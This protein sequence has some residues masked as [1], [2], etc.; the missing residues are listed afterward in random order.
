MKISIKNCNNIDS[1]EIIIKEN[2]LNIK[3]AINGTGKSSISKAILYKS[4]DLKD[5]TNKILDLKPYKA[6]NDNSIIPEINGIDKYKNVQIF[7]EDYVNNYVFQGNELIKGSF[8]IFIKNDAYE[9]G[10]QEI[11]SLVEEIKTIL[12]EDK[13]IEIL[14]RDFNEMINAFGSN[15]K[16]GLDGRSSLAKAFKNGNKVENIPQELEIYT[17]YIRSSENYKWIKWQIDGQTFIDLTENCPYCV[18]DIKEKKGIIKKVAQ[19]YDAKIIE[20]MNKI[21]SVFERLDAYFSNKTKNIISDFVKN[22]DGYTSEQVDFFKELKDQI[23]RLRAKFEN[24]QNLGFY[25]LKDVDKVVDGLKEYFIDLTLYSHMESEK[26]KEKVNIVNNAL[27]N[28]QQKAGLL[29]GCIKRQQQLI[30]EIVCENKADINSFL[31]NA[32][33]NYSVDLLEETDGSRRLKLIY[34]ETEKIV[35]DVKNHLSFGEKNAIA[36]ILFMY[37]A[38]KKN[39]DLIILDD[40]ISSF[41]KNKK[42]AIIDMLFKKEKFLKGKTVLMLTHDID[43]IV[44]MMLVHSDRFE[45]P[46]ASFLENNNGLLIEKEIGRDDIKTF[47]KICKENIKE[48]HNN[49]NKLVY[50]R[51]LCELTDKNSIDYQLI[52]NLFHK[53]ETPCIYT[54]G[55]TKEMSPEEISK[56]EQRIKTIIADFSYQDYIAL[57][58]NDKDMI[59]SYFNAINNYEKLHFYRIIFDDKTSLIESDA[60]RKFI[61]ESFHIE[62]NYIYQLN[63]CK[64]QVVPQYI[65]SECDKHIKKLEEEIHQAQ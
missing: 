11:E 63:P 22:I 9:N 25:S 42:Y 49:L 26:T 2:L 61:N 5:N 60:I 45:V 17:E 46:F 37:D 52:S 55:Q 57:V 62:N 29:Q 59:K 21:V 8:D 31:K 4:S 39:P 12:K 51:R 14:K 48:S 23:E 56:G 19:S 64:Y 32:G 44:D 6:D 24:A 20:N 18:S 16:K 36:L 50:Y 38:L 30:E 3:Y 7:S 58:K 13:E 1:G 35:S 27:S 65:I 10:I 40:P 15:V 28:I 47:I 41:D 43:P 34:N 33:Y 53:R 54:N